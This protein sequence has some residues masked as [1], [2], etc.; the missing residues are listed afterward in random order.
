[1]EKSTNQSIDKNFSNL[2][3]SIELAA[4]SSGTSSKQITLVVVTK[5]QPLEHINTLYSLGQCHFGENRV[6]EALPKIDASSTNLTNPP[7][8]WHMIGTIQSRKARTAI[9]H[10]DV[11]HSVASLKLAKRLSKYASESSITVPVLIQCNTSGELSKS[12]LDASTPDKSN[13]HLI[14]TIS[15]ITD[16]PGLHIAGLMTM[17]PYTTNPELSR[18][19]FRNLRILRDTLSSTFQNITFKELSMGMSGDFGVAIQ[20][21]ATIIRVGTYIFNNNI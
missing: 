15:Q 9:E 13:K 4:Q 10:F 7:P 14:E 18:P 1:M 11:I 19:T 16:L 6:E 2:L 17:A 8:T 20:E 5:K 21:G 3:E 12:G